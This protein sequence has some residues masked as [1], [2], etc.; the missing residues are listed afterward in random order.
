M[1]RSPRLRAITLAALYALLLASL[2][3]CATVGSSS[4]GLSATIAEAEAR[5]FDRSVRATCEPPGTPTRFFGGAGRLSIL[6]DCDDAVASAP[7]R[8]DH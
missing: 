5:E 4:R 3:G 1:H 6:K 7:N 8:I 2:G